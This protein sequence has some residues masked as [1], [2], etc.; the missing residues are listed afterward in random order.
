MQSDNI[1]DKII[2][3]KNK[4][5]FLKMEKWVVIQKMGRELGGGGRGEE[6]APNIVEQDI[7]E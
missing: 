4:N 1:V 2:K 5:S 7:Y 3:V 6:R